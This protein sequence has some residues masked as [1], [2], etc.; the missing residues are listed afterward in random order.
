MRCLSAVPVV[1]RETLAAAKS[2]N[3]RLHAGFRYASVEAWFI[4]RSERRVRKSKR[5]ARLQQQVTR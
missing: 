3:R 1:R 5:K 2:A 4:S